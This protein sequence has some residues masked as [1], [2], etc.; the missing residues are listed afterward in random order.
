M[1][2]KKKEELG[3]QLLNRKQRE[4]LQNKIKKMLEKEGAVNFL[5]AVYYVLYIE[6][7]E[8]DETR[9]ALDIKDAVFKFNPMIPL[10]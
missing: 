10:F 9:L 1:S 6:A 3:K 8:A 2:K 7:V 4:I 5:L